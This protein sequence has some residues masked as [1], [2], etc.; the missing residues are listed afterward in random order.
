MTSHARLLH[1]ALNSLG[2]LRPIIVGHTWG[3]TLALAYALQF[4]AEV[5]ALVLVASAACRDK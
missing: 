4:A 3:G 5:A 1:G 2:V